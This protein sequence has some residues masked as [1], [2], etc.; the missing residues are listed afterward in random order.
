MK[1]FETY[2]ACLQYAVIRPKLAKTT[3][4]KIIANL[5]FPF[6]CIVNGLSFVALLMYVIVEAEEFGD[7]SES[8][9]GLITTASVTFVLGV[10]YWKELE[11]FNLIVTFRNMIEESEY[12]KVN[13]LT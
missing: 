4:E 13:M 7:Y 11:H 12:S 10:C 1:M 8:I 2:E 3:F 6:I 5:K 9:Y